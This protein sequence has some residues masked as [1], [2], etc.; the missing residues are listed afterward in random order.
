MQ[1][2]RLLEANAALQAELAAI[3]RMVERAPLI[4]SSSSG[5][6]GGTGSEALMGP[7]PADMYS[8]QDKVGCSWSSLH[9]LGRAV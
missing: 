9:Q 1:V 6:K 5:G 4:A 8:L 2:S 3:Q 7:G